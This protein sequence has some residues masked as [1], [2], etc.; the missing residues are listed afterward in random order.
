M[1]NNIKGQRIL[2]PSATPARSVELYRPA[3]MVSNRPIPICA[4]CVPMSGKAR[5]KRAPVSIKLLDTESGAFLVIDL[6]LL[7]TD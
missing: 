3:I 6:E 5:R 1:T 7:C 2:L 4:I